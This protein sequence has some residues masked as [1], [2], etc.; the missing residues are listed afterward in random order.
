MLRPSQVS[1]IIAQN[2]DSAAVRGLLKINY[3]SRVFVLGTRGFF[4]RAADGNTLLCFG[5]QR[6]PVLA[7]CARKTSGT[8]G[9]LSTNTS[10]NASVK[11]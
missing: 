9:S 8:L 5:G 10:Y 1:K 4:S 6:P 11:P 3:A 2:K 7:N